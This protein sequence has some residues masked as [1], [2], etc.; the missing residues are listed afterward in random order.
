MVLSPSRVMLLFLLLA[1]VLRA[2]IPAGYMPDMSGKAFFQMT[3]CTLNGPETITVDQDMQP[4]D[5]H[6]T[7]ADKQNGCDFAL[8]G[9]TT[10]HEF[11]VVDFIHFLPTISETSKR[12]AKDRAVRQS[13][14]H[15]LA[16][17]RAPPVAV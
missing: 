2:V 17:P 10:A 14:L 7:Q 4:I 16:Q 1:V 12:I 8:L 5:A 9:H 6:D 13:V 11:A 15:R 3:I